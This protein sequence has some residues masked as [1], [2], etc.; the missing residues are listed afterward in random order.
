[1]AMKFQFYFYA[2][3]HLLE[4]DPTNIGEKMKPYKDV[5]L[6]PYKMV[7]QFLNTLGYNVDL[8][9]SEEVNKMIEEA[10]KK[11]P[12]LSYLQSSALPSGCY[13]EL[14]KYLNS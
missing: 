5:L 8:S 10:R 3:F 1:M 4:N 2:N 6:L 11:Y 14:N 13:E 7:G 12:L 9:V